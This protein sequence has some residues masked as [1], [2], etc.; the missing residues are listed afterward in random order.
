K[1]VGPKTQKEIKPKKHIY[2]EEALQNTTR[3]YQRY[4]K[5][6]GRS[7]KN[8][9]HA[10]GYLFRFLGNYSELHYLSYN[11]AQSFQSYLIEEHRQLSPASVSNIIGVVSGFYDYQKQQ[12]MI[13]NNPFAL[14]DRI[15]VP[16]KLPSWIPNE[17]EMA[18]LLEALG[19]FANGKNLRAYKRDY[20]AHILCEL[21]YST[22]MRISE[23]AELRLEDINL[24]DATLLIH[25]VKTRSQRTG[26]LNDYVRRILQIYIQE[27]R[28]TTGQI[29]GACLAAKET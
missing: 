3:T 20:K 16:Q 24:E 12:G 28:N 18:R 9:R 17:K 6:Q 8:F 22:G 5:L 27:F 13:A 23:A 25:D 15:K 7:T 4:L 26:F 1:K 11:Q 10:F 19:H 21:L 29:P 14:I 2:Q